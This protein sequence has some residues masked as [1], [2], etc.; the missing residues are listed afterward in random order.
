MSPARFRWGLLL[1]LIGALVI[2]AKM[3]VIASD[4][5]VVSFLTMIA[6]F[7]IAIGVEKI[8]NHTRL[9]FISYLSSVL[10]V[11]GVSLLA[12]E[13]GP[14]RS[15]T[16]FFEPKT[17]REKME[18]SISGIQAFVDLG[19]DDLTIR[20]ATEDLVWAKFDRYTLKPSYEYKI[21]GDQAHIKLTPTRG[22]FF[23]GIVHFDDDGLDEWRLKF[24][25]K[26]PLDLELL[27]DRSDIH[28][29]LSSIPL[30]RLDL[31]ADDAEIYLRLGDFLPEVAVVISGRDSRVKLRIPRQAGLKV[32]GVEDG[33]YLRRVGLIK[34]GGSY[35]SEGY[36]S[37]GNRIQ[38]DFDEDLTSISIDFY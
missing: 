10:F 31:D 38:V 4:F 5:W 27:G 11:A 22:R 25:R 37:L 19:S 6:M 24:S 36:D 14:Y 30:R 12:F 23:G 18:S 28:L 34:E 29:N 8:F 3:D 32:S 13:A 15:D 2:L 9:K 33:D 35:Y 16:T 26:A 1:I 20:E 17:I 21:E 7:L